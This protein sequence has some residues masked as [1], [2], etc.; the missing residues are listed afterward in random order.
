MIVTQQSDQNTDSVD[1]IT[2]DFIALIENQ[3]IYAYYFKDQDV[4]VKH[5]YELKRLTEFVVGAPRSV[6][7][8]KN[9]WKRTWNRSELSMNNIIRKFGDTYLIEVQNFIGW[10]LYGRFTTDII[11]DQSV[12]SLK[13]RLKKLDPQI[14]DYPAMAMKVSKDQL[15]VEGET[16]SEEEAI[17]SIRQQ[18]Y[19]DRYLETNAARHNPPFIRRIFGQYDNLWVPGELAKVAGPYS[20]L[21]KANEAVDPCSRVRRGVRTSLD[22]R[23]T[24]KPH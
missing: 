11:I 19:A 2:T 18:G 24:L 23:P 9:R 16:Y 15:A 10:C 1:A 3:G 22:S 21:E 6:D 12:K 20:R 8:H 5:I 4:R 7:E 13:A 14:I 17:L